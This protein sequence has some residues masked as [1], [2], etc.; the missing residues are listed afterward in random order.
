MKFK[1]MGCGTI[2]EGSSRKD[3]KFTTTLDLRGRLYELEVWNNGLYRI[4]EVK[5]GEDIHG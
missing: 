3:L 2:H 4:R 5:Y 1:S